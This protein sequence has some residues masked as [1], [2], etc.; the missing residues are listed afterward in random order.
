MSA[1]E[2][3]YRFISIRKSVV[4]PSTVYSQSVVHHS[5]TPPLSGTKDPLT[6]L[7]LPPSVVRSHHHSA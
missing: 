7:I 1:R 6:L 2:D 4:I 5:E 3:G